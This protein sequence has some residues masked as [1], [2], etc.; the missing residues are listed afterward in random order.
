MALQLQ[1]RSFSVDEFHRMAEAGILREGDR[2]ELIHGEVVTMIPIGSRH[3]AC[4]MRLTELFAGQVGERAHLSVQNPVRMSDDSEPQPD[5]ALLRRRS[6]FYAGSHPG[7]TDVLLLVEVAGTSAEE[8]RSVK[9]PL[10]ARAGICEVWLVDLTDQCVEI[11]R[12]P[13]ADGYQDIRRLGR[14]DHAN[15]LSFPDIRISIAAVL[16]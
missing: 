8:D 2:V 1:R 13:T 16:G 11:L 4:T 3:A 15:L 6:D 5:L 12:R 10:Y 7:P 9:L 14:G